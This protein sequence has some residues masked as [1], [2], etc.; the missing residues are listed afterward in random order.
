MFS[1]RTSG[2]SHGQMAVPASLGENVSAN[3]KRRHSKGEK[4]SFQKLENLKKFKTFKHI[5]PIGSM[6]DIFTYIWLIF[7]VNVGKYTSLMDGMGHDCSLYFSMRFL[8]RRL[9]VC[10]NFVFIFCDQPSPN[11]TEAPLS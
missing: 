6:Y 11:F 4:L 1:L 7:M 5:S 3:P 8:Q 9:G 10:S 2:V